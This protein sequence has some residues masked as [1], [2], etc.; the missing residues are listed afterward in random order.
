M[1]RNCQ[2]PLPEKPE[3]IADLAIDLRWTGRQL[4]DRI[5]RLLD[6]DAWER[7]KNPIM[8]L[9][10]VSQTGLGEAENNESLMKELRYP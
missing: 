6:S 2:R 8:I 5:W 10:N 7:S 4:T 3:S 9:E 1:N